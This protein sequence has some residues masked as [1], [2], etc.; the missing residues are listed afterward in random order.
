MSNI[1]IIKG[2]YASFAKG[3]VPAVLGAMNPHIR[4]TE[5]EGFIYGGE[6]VGPEAILQNVFMKFA[7]EWDG[8]TVTPDKFIDGGEEV[9]VLGKYSGTFLATGKTMT[10]P[11]AHVW[12]IGDD[13]RVSN[14]IQF[15][16]TA[17]IERKLGL[18]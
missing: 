6:Y 1:D 17:L 8:F 11:F 13:S 16:D 15:T 7:T 5:A 18:K 9:V 14:F 10:V 3:D 4:W 2:L 12:T